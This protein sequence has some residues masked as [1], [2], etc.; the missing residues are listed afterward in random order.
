M[1]HYVDCSPFLFSL[2]NQFQIPSYRSPLIASKVQ[3]YMDQVLSNTQGFKRI[4]MYSINLN[5]DFKPNIFH[6]RVYPILK[7]WFDTDKFPFDY[8]GLKGWMC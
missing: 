7:M 2:E 5:K 3:K 1:N 4:F 8:F 6:R